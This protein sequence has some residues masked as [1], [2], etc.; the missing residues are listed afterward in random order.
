LGPWAR[1]SAGESNRNNASKLRSGIF[2]IL[3]QIASHEFLGKGY[4]SCGQ[5]A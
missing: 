2:I 3:S 1:K 4:F 5:T